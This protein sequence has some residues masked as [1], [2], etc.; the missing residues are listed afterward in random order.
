MDDS[1]SPLREMMAEAGVSSYHPLNSLTAAQAT[2]MALLL[3]KV[4]MAAKST[5]SVP[6]I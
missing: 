1:K 2:L 4:M 5:L 6:H 3:L